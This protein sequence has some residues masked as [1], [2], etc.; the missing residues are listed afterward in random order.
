M[1]AVEDVNLNRP[2]H[3][4]GALDD[5]KFEQLDDWEVTLLCWAH[6]DVNSG[7]PVWLLGILQAEKGVGCARYWCNVQIVPADV[8]MIQTIIVSVRG[9]IM[10]G[11]NLAGMRRTK[12]IH[13]Y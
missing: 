4:F 12:R 11:G 7:E 10:S 5:D 8:E 1:N 6:L 13:S 9:T 2:L 3:L